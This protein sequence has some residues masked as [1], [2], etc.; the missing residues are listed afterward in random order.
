MFNIECRSKDIMVNG[1]LTVVSFIYILCESY[2]LTNS[3]I[4]FR[5]AT[6]SYKDHPEIEK[7]DVYCRS[8]QDMISIRINENKSIEPSLASL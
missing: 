1:I 2:E 8:I 7:L 4:I 3:L 6:I 5:N